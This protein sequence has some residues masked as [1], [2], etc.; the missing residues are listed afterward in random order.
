MRVVP[1]PAL[2]G[3]EAVRVEEFAS[4]RERQSAGP[5]NRFAGHEA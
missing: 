5:I 1:S 3:D 4:E 2:T